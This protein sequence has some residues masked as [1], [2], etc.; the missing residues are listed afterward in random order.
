MNAWRHGREIY[1]EKLEDKKREKEEREAAALQAAAALD[2]D[3]IEQKP[4]VKQEYLT[5]FKIGTFLV[6]TISFNG[7]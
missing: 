3:R 4:N 7:L 1:V 2:G 5:D 6:W